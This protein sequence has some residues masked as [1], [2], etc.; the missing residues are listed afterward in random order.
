MSKSTEVQKTIWKPKKLIRIGSKSH[1]DP[2]N[3][4]ETLEGDRD[5]EQVHKGPEN[6]VETP[7]G[8]G[9]MS[10]SK[11]I[12]KAICKPQEVETVTDKFSEVPKTIYK[13]KVVL[14]EIGNPA[15]NS[16]SGTGYILEIISGKG[17]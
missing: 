6:H 1:T 12:Q 4:I 8:N 15:A 17:K 7:E 14:A 3:H 2:E 10:K 16:G 5:K 13:Y 9:D 11:D